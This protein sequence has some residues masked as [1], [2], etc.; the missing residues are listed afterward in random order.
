MPRTYWPSF[1]TAR[2]SPWRCYTS[3]QKLT[4]GPPVLAKKPVF[5]SHCFTFHKL[6]Y[7]FFFFILSFFSRVIP[8]PGQGRVGVRRTAAAAGH[9]RDKQRRGPE[10]IN[11]CLKIEGHGTA[12]WNAPGYKWNGMGWMAKRA[13]AEGD[14]L[15]PQVRVHPV[16]ITNPRLN[17]SLRGAVKCYVAQSRAVDKYKESISFFFL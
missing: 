3:R 10:E 11:D 1:L 4:P 8:T 13:E 17:S 15:W 16:L 6:G 14:W 5:A 2:F 9:A 7:F 12:F